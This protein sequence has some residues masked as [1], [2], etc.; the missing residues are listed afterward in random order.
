MS[1]AS[2]HPDH[3]HTNTVVLGTLI[4]ARKRPRGPRR[5]LNVVACDTKALLPHCRGSRPRR[6]P[7]APG[8][9]SRAGSR[10][11]MTLPRARRHWRA[12]RRPPAG[13]LRFRFA[14]VSASL[15]RDRRRR[16]DHR[17]RRCRRQRRPERSTTS[18]AWAWRTHLP[19]RPA[20]GPAAGTG[21]RRRLRFTQTVGAAAPGARAAPR[22]AP[23]LRPV[24][25][26]DRV[27]DAD[28]TL[29]ADGRAEIGVPG[30]SRFPR[31]WIYGTDGREPA[32]SPG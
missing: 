1:S 25:G 15:D 20:I 3:F 26:A 4:S 17:G 30:A 21:A 32:A 6:S 12:Q 24:G 10:I 23:A 27:D 13:S 31:H 22:R 19:G 16:P 18:S 28:L 2:A 29:H 5:Q 8:P 7:E 11:T 9:R 14:N